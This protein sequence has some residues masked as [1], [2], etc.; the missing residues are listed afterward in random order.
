MRQGRCRPTLVAVASQQGKIFAIG[1]RSVVGGRDYALDSVE[2]Y[3]VATD[4]WSE[5]NPMVVAS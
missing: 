1:G 5:A 2:V 3:D 4:R